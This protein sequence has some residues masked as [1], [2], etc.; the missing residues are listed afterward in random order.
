MRLFQVYFADNP[1][2]QTRGIGTILGI[3]DSTY[4]ASQIIS[5]MIMGYIML[6]FKSTVSYIVI[7]FLLAI[8]S[9]WFINRI[10]INRHQLQELMKAE[11]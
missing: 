7:S 3:L 8:C 1:V 6:I 5:S 9:L 4:F 11:K 10:V 2:I